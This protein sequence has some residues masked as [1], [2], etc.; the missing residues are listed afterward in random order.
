MIQLKRIYDPPDPD[1][2]I[3]ILVDR[4]WPRGMKKENLHMDE[5]IRD[6]APSDA[7]RRWF[8]HDPAKWDEFRRRYS[9]ELEKNPESWRPIFN[10]V[11]RSTITLLFSTHNLEQNNAVALKSFL[12][13]QLE[14]KISET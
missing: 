1:D 3:R 14:R 12:E 9:I 6:V 8:A 4:L 2:G 10:A 11:K 13:K 5:W 7:L